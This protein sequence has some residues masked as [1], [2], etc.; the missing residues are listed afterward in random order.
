[1][2]TGCGSVKGGGYLKLTA[3]N[4]VDLQGTITAKYV[5]LMFS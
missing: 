1:M 3:V 2:G 4:K 5:C